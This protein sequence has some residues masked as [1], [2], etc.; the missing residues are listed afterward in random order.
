MQEGEQAE[1]GD[2]ALRLELQQLQARRMLRTLAVAQD[3]ADAMLA[4][5]DVRGAHPEAGLCCLQHWRHAAQL[6]C[7]P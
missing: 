4:L 5:N 1:H 3:L 2:S 7:K 6:W